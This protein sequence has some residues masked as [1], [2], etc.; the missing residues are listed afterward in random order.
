METRVCRQR[1]RSVRS[2]EPGGIPT[3]GL[4]Q[5]Q[6]R[7]WRALLP[8]IGLACVL[9]AYVWAVARLH[10]TN[11]FGI[12]E[13][14]TFYFSSAKSI[15][16]GHGYLVPSLPGAPAATKYPHL[17]PWLLSYVWRWNPSFPANLVDAI[18]VSV[19]F[20]LAF[21][22]LTFLY[23]RQAGRLKDWEA[24]AIT[25]FCAL[26]P[27]VLFYSG[28]VLTE[29]PFAALVLASL[30]TAD[31]ATWPDSRLGWA[32]LCGVLAG[33]SAE[34]RIFGF[35]IIGGIAIAAF[36]RRARR[37]LL[38]FSGTAGV[39]A[40]SV[41][42]RKMFLHATQ[43]ANIVRHPG[44]GWD[45][46]WTYDTSYLGFW[47]MSIPNRHVFFAMLANNFEVLL[48]T[49]SD[50][51]LKSSVLMRGELGVA[52]W[53]IVAAI[54]VIAF[55]REVRQHGWTPLCCV[56]PLY[57]LIALFWNYDAFYRFFL[58]FLPVFITGYW[59][60][61]KRLAEMI[62]RA[63]TARKVRS[64]LVAATALAIA[65][66]VGNSF[67]AWDYVD[68]SSR[69]VLTAISNKRAALLLS[70]RQAYRWI[71]LSTAPNARIIAY[72]D[73]ELYLYTNRQAMRPM[74]FT[75]AEFLD[76]N[77]LPNGVAHITDVARAIGARYWFVSQDDFDAEW[78]A[79]QNAA[80]SRMHQIER[81]L[82]LGFRSSDGR[83]S[84]YRLGCIEDPEESRCSN[85]DRV[86]FPDD[87][88]L[89]TDVRGRGKE[90][91]SPVDSGHAS[92]CQRT[93]TTQSGLAARSNRAGFSVGK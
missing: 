23:L 37:Q 18:G 65:I 91:L 44:I 90:G 58:P 1:E 17:Y 24:L 45:R 72:Q 27:I 9:G 12:L 38:A 85:V 32:F 48:H 26:H 77:R 39:L 63:L 54:V 46:V 53:A 51:L 36:L 60:E 43:P 40:V 84:I 31:R 81:V 78:S 83:V 67:I 69:T 86:L 21:L 87:K 15:A 19:C 41:F 82:P 35:A 14:D 7:R 59:F 66:V 20:G 10:P 88:P 13:D 5:V 3:E 34:M 68:G 79:E 28:S 30:L 92:K 71:S 52:V 89:S 11:F 61:M 64:D 80:E 25:A 74:V 62:W 76:P 29:I 22:T 4:T 42:W 93:V 55:V 56:L 33:L 47:R 8:W 70:E 50:Y 49:P 16:Q 6:P 75:T 2:D 73:A 57:V